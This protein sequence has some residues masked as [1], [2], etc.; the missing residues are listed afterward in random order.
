MLMGTDERDL[1]RGDDFWRSW[2]SERG[3]FTRMCAYWLSGRSHDVED[4]MSLG[5]I[6][7]RAYLCDHPWA[8][9]HLRPW[10]LRLLRNLCI[11][12]LRAQGRGAG[13]YVD[14]ED[15]V[16][17]LIVPATPLTPEH[18]L[19]RGELASA[20][21]RAVA[22]LPP[23]LRVAFELRFHDQLSYPELSQALEITQE[24]ARKRVQQARQRLREELGDHAP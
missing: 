15:R 20:L 11:D 4:V 3:Y 6:K 19:Y 2:L 10:A 1:G 14:D 16:A 7:A 22:A 8:V 17:D 24:N 23:R 9:R 13:T 18:E 21:T 5:A 12:H